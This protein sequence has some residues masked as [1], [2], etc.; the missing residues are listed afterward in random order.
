MIQSAENFLIFSMKKP[1]IQGNSGTLGVQIPSGVPLFSLLRAD[2]ELEAGRTFAPSRCL[3][4]G[5]IKRFRESLK[6]RNLNLFQRSKFGLA[7]L[8]RGNW[9]NVKN[10]KNI[11]GMS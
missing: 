7:M 11:S 5:K 2:V 4:G 3:T 9:L 1:C 6:G 10:L 8:V